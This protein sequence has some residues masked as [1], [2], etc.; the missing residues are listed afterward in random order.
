MSNQEKKPFHIHIVGSNINIISKIAKEY[1]NIGYRISKN[2]S[3]KNTAT[4][5][6]KISPNLILIEHDTKTN[7]AQ[8]YK[9][10]TYKDKK[11]RAH[12]VLIIDI[13]NIEVMNTLHDY[14]YDDYFLKPLL[15]ID[16]VGK[17]GLKIKE[18]NSKHKEEKQ[19]LTQFSLNQEMNK[20][21]G[22]LVAQ[23]EKF[24]SE[25]ISV[26]KRLSKDNDFGILERAGAELILELI[27]K[28]KDKK[29][30]EL[31]Y[32]GID[33]IEY[34]I[35]TFGQEAAN[36]IILSMSGL[37]VSNKKNNEIIARWEGDRFVLFCSEASQSDIFN[38][39]KNIQKKIALLKMTK[40]ITITCSTLCCTISKSQ[41]KDFI[42]SEMQANMA[43]IK[44]FHKRRPIH[45]R[46]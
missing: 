26:V 10:Y 6:E 33:N 35:S 46:I 2:T 11:D 12:V 45:I 41:S 8:F 24:N 17:I 22:K 30:F 21:Q 9:E 5:L 20:I 3:L 31:L 36:K 1:S 34:I 39:A 23:E 19:R 27:M 13:K 37:L 25:M 42:F 18:H 44:N 43:K 28:K 14:G 32:V 16:Y 15:K 7:Y 29:E 38:I 40:D 4:V